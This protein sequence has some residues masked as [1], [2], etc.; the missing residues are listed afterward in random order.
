MAL[1]KTSRT[2][3][4]DSPTYF[5]SSAGPLTG[6]KLTSVWL[7]TALASIVLPQPGG[8][9]SRIP[10]GRFD[11]GLSED[12]GVLER[13]L[14][15]LDQLPFDLVQAPHL[16]PRDVGNLDEDLADGRGLDLAQRPSKSVILTSSVRSR[17]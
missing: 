2:P 17:S 10:R 4:S 11:T 14:D 9:E 15:G 16:L 13:P 12:L 5:E 8:P 6:M 3:L 7:A 1:R